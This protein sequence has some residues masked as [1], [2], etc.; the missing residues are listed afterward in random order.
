[1]ATEAFGTNL[2]RTF[3]PKYTHYAPDGQGRDAYII[4]HNGGLCRERE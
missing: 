4:R 2:G 3:N 1:M